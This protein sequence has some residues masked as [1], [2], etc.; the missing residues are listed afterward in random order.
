M[1]YP[2]PGDEV[3]QKK[4]PGA[5]SRPGDPCGMSYLIAYNPV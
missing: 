3:P 1:G 2:E 5:Q 4:I